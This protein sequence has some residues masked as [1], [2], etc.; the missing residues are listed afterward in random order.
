M[1]TRV[2]LDHAAIE[3]ILKSREMTVAVTELA[4]AVADEIRDQN[5]TVG[6]FKGGGGEIDLPVEVDVYETD[7]A[8]A[9]VTIKHPAGLA[10]QARNGWLTKAASA[11]GL[12]VNGD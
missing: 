5:I 7:R 4:E 9:S 6:A 3:R 1:A 8:R 12:E 10:G 11:L 2:H